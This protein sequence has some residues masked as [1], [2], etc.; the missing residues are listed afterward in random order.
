MGEE[1]VEADRRYDGLDPDFAGTEP[2]YL[3][4]AVEHE[5]QRADADPQSDE[6]GPVEAQMRLQFGL[7][8]EGQQAEH[9]DD[10]DRQVDQEDPMPGVIVGQPGAD[11]RAH[12]RP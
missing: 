5:L 8:H 9:G 10:A 3:L 6:T 1:I 4:A 7:V 12:D 2:A 11:G